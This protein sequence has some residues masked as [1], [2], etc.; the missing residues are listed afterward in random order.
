MRKGKVLKENLSGN[1][2]EK[3]ATS[4]NFVQNENFVFILKLVFLENIL[5][6]ESEKAA[7]F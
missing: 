3:L 2:E 4:R 6:S 1:F 7:S 5:L